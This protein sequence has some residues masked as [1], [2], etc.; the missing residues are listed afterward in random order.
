MWAFCIVPLRMKAISLNV[1]HSHFFISDFSSFLI[2]I[3][4]QNSLYFKSL[5]SSRVRDKIDYCFVIYQ[6]FSAPIFGYVAK[7]LLLYLL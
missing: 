5:F 3:G 2:F 7:Q 1:Y 4:I 6:R